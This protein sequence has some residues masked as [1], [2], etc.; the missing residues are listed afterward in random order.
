MTVGQRRRVINEIVTQFKNIN[1]GISTY[2]AFYTYLTNLNNNVFRRIKFLHEVN[3]FPSVY[4]Q[5]DLESRTYHST[6]LTEG[7][8]P[9]VIR[10][11]VNSPTPINDLENLAQDIEH[12]L[13]NWTTDPT[14]GIMDITIET[15]S[16]DEGLLEPFGI[17]EIFIEV[18]YELD[19]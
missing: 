5:A 8:L 12:I 16:N 10:C 2:D 18:Q 4:L 1:G 6:G 13:Y 17:G 15:I 19:R 7:F 11:Y 14:L 3:D 9:I